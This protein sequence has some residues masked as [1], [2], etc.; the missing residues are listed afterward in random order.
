MTDREKSLE[1]LNA[2]SARVRSFWVTYILLCTYLTI[3]I[4]SV[5]HKMLLLETPINLPLLNVDLPLSGF[6][7]LAPALLVICHA[8]LLLQIRL[9]RRNAAHHICLNSYAK[10]KS[11]KQ[12]NSEPLSIQVDSFVISQF[13]IAKENE[14]GTVVYYSLACISILTLIF[15]PIAILLFAL[16]QFLPYHH[17]WITWWH[18]LLTVVDIITLIML[19]SPTLKILSLEAR[20]QI[21]RRNLSI[22]VPVSIMFLIVPSYPGEIHY[23]VMKSL[24]FIPRTVWPL[25]EIFSEIVSPTEYLFEGNVNSVSGDPNSM[26]SNRLVVLNEDLIDYR[27]LES[28]RKQE[29]FDA[30]LQEGRAGNIYLKP[31][32]FKLINS[33]RGRDLRGAILDYS[34]LRRSDFT[35]ADMRGA[36]LTGALLSRSVFGCA[37]PKREILNHLKR[38]KNRPTCTQLN[39][40]S[41]ALTNL[42]ESKFQGVRARGVTFFSARIQGAVFDNFGTR[43]DPKRKEG[44]DEDG[45]FVELSL[46]G[47]SFKK[48]DLQGAIFRDVD[49]R[50]TYFGR[51]NLHAASFIDSKMSGASFRKASAFWADFSSTHLEGA[52]FYRAN[53]HG[54][55]FEKS[56]IAHTKFEKSTLC[57]TD[58][59]LDPHYER[60]L[61]DLHLAHCNGTWHDFSS[62]K[63][64]RYCFDKRALAMVTSIAKSGVSSD[65]S[66]DRIVERIQ[67]VNLLAYKTNEKSCSKE[68]L[69]EN[70]KTIDFE[71][72]S[73]FFEK[74]LNFDELTYE[75]QRSFYILS[76]FYNRE[77]I[78]DSDAIKKTNKYL[79]K[80]L[81]RNR[82]VFYVHEEN[83]RKLGF[84][85]ALNSVDKHG[86]SFI[87]EDLD[88]DTRYL[89]GEMIDFTKKEISKNKNEKNA[90]N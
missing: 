21:N 53:L 43:P 42:Q 69:D 61:T 56:K 80:G 24:N 64:E 88:D 51:S 54:A 7:F 23:N 74:T 87:Y 25:N 12:L 5:S 86:S 52:S 78:E 29:T 85:Q 58:G 28:I 2:I 55:K 50:A 68:K 30:G 44:G 90:P 4:G 31:G 77:T 46:L 62:A 70:S 73:N 35:A 32:D 26:F 14:E 60:P 20:H 47:S 18:R 3:S 72:P 38:E 16:V 9:L 27:F 59:L 17:A 84:L 19:W 89:L 65:V 10:E 49:L 36:K 45:S 8:Y 34:D 81:V 11:D 66:R 6:F 67:E 40:A 15:I 39:D 57:Q 76:I 37:D 41:F 22:Y 13:L 48:A 75:Y 33:F 83:D 1:A 71:K 63:D 82:Q 79:R